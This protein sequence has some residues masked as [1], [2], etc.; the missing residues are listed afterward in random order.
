LGEPQG[1]GA[2]DAGGR[3]RDEGYF[4]GRGGH[5]HEIG[6]IGAEAKPKNA[7]PDAPGLVSTAWN[8]LDWYRMVPLKHLPFW[9]V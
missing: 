7:P 1:N 2:P 8:F 5:G 3:A 9:A 4:L 6:G